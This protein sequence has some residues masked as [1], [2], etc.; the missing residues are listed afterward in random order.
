MEKLGELSFPLFRCSEA[1]FQA[2]GDK[3]QRK[4]GFYFVEDKNIFILPYQKSEDCYNFEEERELL[5][6]LASDEL[7]ES[8]LR[9]PAVDEALL[10]VLLKPSVNK[11]VKLR[12]AGLI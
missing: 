10:K 4:H 7:V 9:N 8:V 2:I 5:I 6:S 12:K 3:D 11:L 1:E